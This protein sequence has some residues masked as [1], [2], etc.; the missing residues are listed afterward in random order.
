MVGRAESSVWNFA[1]LSDNTS[2]TDQKLSHSGFL[3]ASVLL[4]RDLLSRCA[5]FKRL[6]RGFSRWLG[7]LALAP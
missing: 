5:N 4:I 7:G 2:H 1:G 3:R 6:G